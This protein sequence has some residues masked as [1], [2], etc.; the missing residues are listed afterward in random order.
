MGRVEILKNGIWGTVCMDQF[1]D[2]DAQ[3]ACRQMGHRDGNVEY[4]EHSRGRGKVWMDDVGCTG[5]ENRLQDCKFISDGPHFDCP[6]HELDVTITCKRCNNKS[7]AEARLVNSRG[8]VIAG[9]GIHSKK[10]PGISRRDTECSPCRTCPHGQTK[11]G[12]SCSD[13]LTDT[14][15]SPCTKCHSNEYI[16]EECTPNSDTVCNPCMQCI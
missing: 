12:G 2:T 14:I 10:A 11:V 8:N 5:R 9:A 16:D 1:R 13:G 6:G 3:V 7:D 15:C 4:R